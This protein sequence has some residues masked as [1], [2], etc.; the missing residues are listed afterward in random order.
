MKAVVIPETTAIFL[1]AVK[2]SRNV[3]GYSSRSKVSKVIIS[4]R[5]IEYLPMKSRFTSAAI[6][7]AGIAEKVQRYCFEKTRPSVAEHFRQGVY[8]ISGS[9]ILILK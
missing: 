9:D 5:G 2:K 4:Q 3:R 6:E 7:R 1:E 8:D